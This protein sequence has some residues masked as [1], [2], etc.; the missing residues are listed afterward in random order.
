MVY[1]REEDEEW[2]K[3]KKKNG[4]KKNGKLTFGLSA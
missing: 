2:K 4:K 1:Y 3:A